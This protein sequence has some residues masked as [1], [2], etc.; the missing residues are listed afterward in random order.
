MID[1]HCH[2]VASD[3][4]YSPSELIKMAE[5]LG[6]THFALTDHDTTDGIKEFISYKSDIKRIPGIEISCEIEKGELHI[7]GLFID[8][9]NRKL[10]EMEE[11]VKYYRKKRNEK[12]ILALSKLMKKNIKVEDLV[13]NPN[14]QLGKPHVA[15]YLL[16]NNVVKSLQDAFDIYLKEGMSLSFKKQQVPIDK[17][18]KVIK[19]AGGISI[20]AHPYT[21]KLNDFM[22]EEQLKKYKILGLDGVEA[23]SS[24]NPIDKKDIFVSM[25]LNN[26]LIISCGSDFHGANGKVASLGANIGNLSDDDI[27][28]P[29]YSI[30]NHRL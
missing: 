15:K 17:A 28:K 6:I 21:L 11:E 18:L 1:L 16:K 13:D 23:Y 8:I 30:I 2:S 7:V 25:A 22:L 9:E 12:M 5:E 29:M 27:L 24:H 10:K 14:S 26:G 3:G 4:S 19:N 20:L